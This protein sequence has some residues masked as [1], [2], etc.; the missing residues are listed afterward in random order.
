MKRAFACD[1]GQA[2]ARRGDKYRS[3]IMGHTDDR[4]NLALKILKT[5]VFLS[6][7][8]PPDP[9]GRLDVSIGVETPVDRS[10]HWVD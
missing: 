7:I 9:T 2:F 3:M 5:I 4:H 8:D 6:G 1:S 10:R